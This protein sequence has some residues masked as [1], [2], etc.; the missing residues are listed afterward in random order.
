MMKNIIIGL[1]EILWDMLPS[2]K[3]LGGAP[4]NFA[5][6]VSQFGFDGYAVSAIGNDLLG[7]EILDNLKEKKLNFLIE[8][9][10]FPTGTVA[11]TIDETGNPQYEICKGV[12]WDNIPFTSQTEMLAKICCA[13]CFGSLAQRSEFSRNTIL[14]F[15]ELV[16]EKALKI[17]DINLRQ[18]FYSKEIIE[19]SLKICNVLKMNDEEMV[20]ISNLFEYQGLSEDAICKKILNDYQMKMVVLTKGETGSYIFTDDIVSY[21]ETPK[22]SVVDTVG[23][24]DSFTGSLVAAL[25]NGKTI[26]EAHRLAV[27]ISAYVCTQQGATPEFPPKLTELFK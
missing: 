22:V 19:K 15:L 16:P 11:V 1:G 20:I 26:Q 13:V 10:G 6:I 4:A 24:G 5:Y 9:V 23:A 12:A 25:F 27:E 3:K 18:H 21:I 8:K 2:G 7:K 14:K 17:F